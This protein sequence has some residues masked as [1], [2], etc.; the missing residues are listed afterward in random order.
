VKAWGKLLD[1]DDKITTEKSM[2]ICRL[3]ELSVVAWVETGSLVKSTQD[4]YLA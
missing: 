1:R 2:S 3:S 4:N